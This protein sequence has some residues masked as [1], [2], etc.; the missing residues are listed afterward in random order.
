MINYWYRL[1]LS[2]LP[3]SNKSWGKQYKNKFKKNLLKVLE[4]NDLFNV[5][6]LCTLAMYMDIEY[7]NRIGL[8]LNELEREKII[9]IFHTDECIYIYKT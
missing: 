5:D 6:D 9:Q 8:S 2:K 7:D 4:F 3:I 1:Q